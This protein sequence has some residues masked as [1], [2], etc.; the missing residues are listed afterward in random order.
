[1]EFDF[2]KPENHTEFFLFKRKHH[3]IQCYELVL[4]SKK[5]LEELI[6]KA[7]LNSEWYAYVDTH[8]EMINFFAKEVWRNKY[9]IN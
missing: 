6:Q 2:P 5:D 3:P 4:H 8:E 7:K 1:M 9:A